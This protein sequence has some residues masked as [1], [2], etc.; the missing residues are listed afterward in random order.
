MKNVNIPKV[1]IVNSCVYRTSDSYVKYSDT[2]YSDFRQGISNLNL[3]KSYI[4]E[5]TRGSDHTIETMFSPVKL[6][7]VPTSISV[8]LVSF[9]SQSDSV[10][11]CIRLLV[12]VQETYK[13]RFLG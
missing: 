13:D 3:I 1:S 2:S 9:R 5:V 4:S 11:L 10:I 8:D 7:P 12:S 6:H